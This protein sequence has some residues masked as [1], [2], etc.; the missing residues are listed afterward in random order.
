MPDPEYRCPNCHVNVDCV[1][2]AVHGVINLYTIEFSD[3]E[4]V[5]TIEDKPDHL[6]YFCPG[7][8][9]PIPGFE[10]VKLADKKEKEKELLALFKKE[11]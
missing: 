4:F 3:F 7:W 10:S 9:E 2:V 11:G 6:T 8:G 1:D 5:D